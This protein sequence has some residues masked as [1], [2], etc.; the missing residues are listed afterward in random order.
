MQGENGITSG[1]NMSGEMHMWKRD[2]VFGCIQ[3]FLSPNYF[4]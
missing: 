2:E 3:A 4:L 1:L